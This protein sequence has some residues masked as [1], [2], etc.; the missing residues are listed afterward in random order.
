MESNKK[1]WIYGLK[2]TT[3]TQQQT[4]YER[5]DLSRDIISALYL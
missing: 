5:H 4:G 1:Y 2:S 3:S